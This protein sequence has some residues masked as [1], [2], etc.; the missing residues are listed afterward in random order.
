MDSNE[1]LL[2]LVALQTRVEVAVLVN[3]GDV[4]DPSLRLIILSWYRID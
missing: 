2:V 4:V 1:F 3:V